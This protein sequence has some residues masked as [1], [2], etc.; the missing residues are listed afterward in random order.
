MGFGKFEAHAAIVLHTRYAQQTRRPVLT[1]NVT[2]G[3]DYVISPLF[4][5]GIELKKFHP[6][7][8]DI[9]QGFDFRADMVAKR[10]ISPAVAL[11]GSGGFGYQSRQNRGQDRAVTEFGLLGDGSVQLSPIRRVT[12][13]ALTRIRFNASGDLH[14]ESVH[15]QVGAGVTG[16]LT[17]QIDAYI[18]TSLYVLPR[19]DAYDYRLLTIGALYRHP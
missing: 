16:S 14:G 3:G 12:L 13:E 1:N 4:T 11:I 18:E 7:G 2:V 19:S 15:I 6:F 17:R 10:I 9:E 8:G 5:A